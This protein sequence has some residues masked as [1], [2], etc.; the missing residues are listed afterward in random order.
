MAGFDPAIHDFVTIQKVKMW[1]AC[2]MPA[3]T[4]QIICFDPK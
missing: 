1:M 4:R 2:I 3:M